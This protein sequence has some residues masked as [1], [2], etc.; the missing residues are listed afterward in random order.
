MDVEFVD[1]TP[2]HRLSGDEPED[3]SQVTIERKGLDPII[4]VIC[5]SYNKD[6]RRYVMQKWGG[7]LPRS[8]ERG[9]FS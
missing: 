2:Y 4:G 3:I 7:D 1:R 9:G 6:H 5:T 8:E